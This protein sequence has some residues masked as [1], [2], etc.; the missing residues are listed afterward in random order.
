MVNSRLASS[1]T[2]TIYVG[3][4]NL[5]LN[6]HGFSQDVPLSSVYSCG[7]ASAMVAK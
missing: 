3:M 7:A 2:Y 5:V 6:G 1:D 4:I